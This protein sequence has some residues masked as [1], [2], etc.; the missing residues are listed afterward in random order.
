MGGRGRYV[1]PAAKLNRAG[2]TEKPIGLIY[3]SSAYHGA[4]M[5][6]LAGWGSE[7]APNME[8]AKARLKAQVARLVWT[9]QPHGNS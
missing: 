7:L 5:W 8:K 4:V 3:E 6:A 9:Q 1:S 2:F